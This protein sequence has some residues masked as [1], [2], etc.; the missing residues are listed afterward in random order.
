MAEGRVVDE[1]VL[2]R[3]ALGDQVGFKDV[4]RRARIDIVRPQQREFLD[5]QLLEEIVRG[6]NGLLVRRGAGVEDVLRRLFT[7]VLH[8]IEQ[9]PVQLLD[10]RQHRLA[11]HR[12]PAAEHHV[13]IR[14]GQQLARLF[15]EQRPVRRRVHHDR[16]QL[17]AQQAALG[18]L[19]LD[20]HQHRVLQGRLR[21]RH[22][23]RQRMQDADLDRLLLRQRGTGE[24]HAHRA[25]QHHSLDPVH[26]KSSFEATGRHPSLSGTGSLS[27]SGNFGCTPCGGGGLPHRSPCRTSFLFFA[28]TQRPAGPRRMATPQPGNADGRL[29]A[30]QSASAAIFA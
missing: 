10:H 5:P 26:V 12:G 23:A 7:L 9:Q 20:Q 13:H 11:R 29:G 4:V 17:L 3:D 6:G 24:G 30:G 1:D 15:G 21:N 16:F 14:H 19:L 8:R 28:G 2:L 22:R 18:V 25:A 27:S